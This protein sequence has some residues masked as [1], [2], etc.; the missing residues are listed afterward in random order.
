MQDINEEFFLFVKRYMQFHNICT[1][2]FDLLSGRYVPSVNARTRDSITEVDSRVTAEMVP[3]IIF[4][5]YSFFS[6]LME[7]SGDGLD[8]FRIWRSKFPEEEDAIAALEQRISSFRNELRIFR[9]RLGF[10]GSRTHK[11]ESKGFDLFNN[12][13]GAKLMNAIVLFKAFNA[14]LL[15]KDL[16][17]QEGSNE[18]IGAAKLSIARIA[19]RCRTE[20]PESFSGDQKVK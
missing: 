19:E 6:S 20:D 3:T 18:R 1:V 17:T 5:V 12:H 11:H 4:L 15:E 7:D 10:H 2:Y 16:A 8:A 13:S 14:A 9:N